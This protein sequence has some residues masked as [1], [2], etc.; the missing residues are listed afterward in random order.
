MSPPRAARWAARAARKQHSHAHTQAH[1]TA[2]LLCVTPTCHANAHARQC[3]SSALADT[4]HLMYTVVFR[5]RP[6]RLARPQCRR[7][8]SSMY[9]GSQRCCYKQ[10]M[11]TT[12][13]TKRGQ[14]AACPPRALPTALPRPHLS[15]E[16]ALRKNTL[17]RALP[18]IRQVRQWNSRTPTLACQHPTKLNT[19]CKFILAAV[20]SAPIRA[21]TKSTVAAPTSVLSITSTTH[22]RSLTHYIE[23]IEAGFAGHGSRRSGRAGIEGIIAHQP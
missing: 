10:R 4:C 15:T 5:R 16:M 2:T 7:T 22:K 3:P 13:R 9:G 14:S 21:T 19:K 12:R 20:C 17:R 6:S 18:L 23:L 11:K 1:R 8:Q